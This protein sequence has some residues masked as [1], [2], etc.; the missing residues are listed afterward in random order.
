[1]IDDDPLLLQA[2]YR[3]RYQV[4]CLERRFLP[5][6]NYPE[7]VE[8]DAYDA[9]SIHLGLVN[10]E[11]ELVATV[12]MV[13]RGA[14]GFPMDAHCQ[15]FPGEP[16]LDHPDHRVVEISRLAVSRHYNKRAGDGFYGLQEGV[17]GADGLERRGGAEIVLRLFKALY[18]TSR[19]RGFTH[20]VSAS[21]RSLRRLVARYGFMSRAIG[22]DCD[23]YGMVSP[24]IV[25]LRDLDAEIAGGEV[26]VLS[27][28]LNGLE[29]EFWPAEAHP[30]PASRS[31]HEPG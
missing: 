15:L 25:D 18:Q 11:R 31:A 12:R 8:T 22:P 7:Q 4:Y 20:W 9:H 6:E 21:E 27:E 26:P 23:Y 14:P 28:F 10:T 3:L 19:R 17:V 30:R 5:A 2:S 13:Q 1:V 29:P 16:R 24:C